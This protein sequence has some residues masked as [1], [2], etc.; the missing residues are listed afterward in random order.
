MTAGRMLPPDPTRRRHRQLHDIEASPVASSPA[1]YAS[2]QPLPTAMK[3]SLPAGGLRLYRVGVEPAGSLRTVSG[4]SSP[5]LHSHPPF[6]GFLDA[7]WAHAR[8]KLVE[9]TRTS[10]APIKDEGV[11]RI[12]DLYRLEAELRGLDPEARLAGRR[13]RAA[14]LIADMEIWLTHRIRVAAKSPQPIHTRHRAHD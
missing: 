10:S 1:V 5:P 6:R 13:E 7:S 12:G 4:H 14:P 11:K 8:R 9:I 3:D 2:P